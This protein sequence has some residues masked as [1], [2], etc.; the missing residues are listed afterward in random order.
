MTDL[1]IHDI[2]ARSA[3]T[4]AIARRWCRAYSISQRADADDALQEAHL[5]VLKALPRYNVRRPLKP[6][7][8]TCIRHRLRDW[9]QKLCRRRRPVRQ[10]VR[11]AAPFD[12]VDLIDL[13]DVAGRLKASDQLLL[14]RL[15]AGET[16]TDIAQARGC[17]RACVW[18][19]QRRLVRRLREL[20]AEE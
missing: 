10:P 13:Q 12:R 2:P 15:L 18:D 1:D 17:T 5:A 20:L 3:F 7:L 9:R 8:A 6:F 11:R 14:S 19:N 16:A 4:T